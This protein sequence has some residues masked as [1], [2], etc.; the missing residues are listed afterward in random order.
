[1]T[2]NTNTTEYTEIRMPADLDI[3]HISVQD[4]IEMLLQHE[5]DDEDGQGEVQYFL[6]NASPETLYQVAAATA[7][8]IVGSRHAVEG[9]IE[10]LVGDTHELLLGCAK[11]EQALPELTGHDTEKLNRT[12]MRRNLTNL[13]LAEMLDGSDPG[14]TRL[15]EEM[16]GAA[17]E[18]QQAL[19]LAIDRSLAE[20]GPQ[21]QELRGKLAD[22]MRHSLKQALGN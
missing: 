5:A 17:A 22:A 15:L 13:N 12:R 14:D 16:K 6:E 8:N 18:S 7:Q 3:L 19:D 9:V 2:T 11:G 20:I 10:V 1:M 4:T 21:I